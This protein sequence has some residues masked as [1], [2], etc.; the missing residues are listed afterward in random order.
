MKI[1]AGSAIAL[2]LS[3][4][5]N[6]FGSYSPLVMLA[7]AA[8]IFFMV[9]SWMQ[10][11]TPVGGRKMV[12]HV[13]PGEL[14]DTIR[15]E[16]GHAL[17]ARKIGG[18]VIRSRVF[19]DG[20]GYVEARFPDTKENRAAFFY[21]GQYAMGSDRGAEYDNKMLRRSGNHKEREAG[22]A[23]ARRIINANRGVIEA[24]GDRI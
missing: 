11:S 3:I 2:L 19:K 12:A 17:V 18:R 14:R 5:T 13:H 21:G 23:L 16:R 6:A 20:S 24:R 15:H 9:R 4:Q 22:K 8:V 1:V 7:S 10:T